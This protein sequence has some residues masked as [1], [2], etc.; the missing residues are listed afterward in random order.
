VVKR[1][2]FRRLLE[3]MAKLRAEGGCPWDREQT[4]ES[5]RAYCIEEAYEVVDA[6]DHKNWDQLRDELGDLLLQVVFHAQM[7]EEAGTFDME[8][9]ISAIQEKLIRRH[10]HVFRKE[11][12]DEVENSG[13][14][15]EKWAKIKKSEGRRHL[16]DGI[17]K[18][19]PALLRASRVGEKAGSVGFDWKSAEEVRA[20][21]D[22]ELA[23]LNQVQ[24][25]VSQTEEELGDLLF[26]L[27]SYSRHLGV[28]A[29]AS[30]RLATE[31]FEKRFRWMEEEASKQGKELSE[32]T[33]IQLDQLWNQ[34]KK[35]V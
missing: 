4:H 26:A 21:I 30:L 12:G 6:I 2:S 20:K 7:A 33:P 22:E 11:K 1:D 32:L 27:T 25:S 9:V 24:E 14:V 16:L 8:D 31:K 35:S 5:I 19:L 29:E 28:D 17:P 18:Y 10:P 23:E 34:A 15:L 3:T 13:Q